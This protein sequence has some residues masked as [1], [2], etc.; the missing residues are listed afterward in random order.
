MSVIYRPSGKALEYAQLATNV[1]LGCDHNCVYCYGPGALKWSRDKYA[2]PQLRPGYPE[3]LDKDAWKLALD[4]GARFVPPILLSFACDPYSPFNDIHHITRQAIDILHSHGLRVTMLTKGGR[5]ALQ[6]MDLFGPGDSMGATLTFTDPEQ[7]REWEPFAAS[8]AERLT[9]LQK[10]HD[11]GIRTWASME[12]VIDP[13]Q[14]LALIYMSAPYI[15]HYKVGMLNHHPLS[16]TINWSKFHDD[17]VA[18]LDSL[19][20]DYY[21]KD[22]LRKAAAK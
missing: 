20:A 22:G 19:G 9:T 8:P 3:A 17:A 6:D 2:C 1:Y 13:D 21:I 5:R 11:A 7:C 15:D 14:T 12:P 4:D 10:F 18:L 16:K